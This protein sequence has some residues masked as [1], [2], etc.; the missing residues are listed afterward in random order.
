MKIIAHGHYSKA[1][2]DT[3]LNDALPPLKELVKETT[4]ESVRRVGRFIQLALIG[5]G[6]CLTL[7][8]SKQKTLPADTA[9]YL[10]SGR[11]DLEITL[12]VLVQMVEH[13]LPPKPLSFINTV[14][15]SA[16]FYIAKHFGIRGRNQFV[17]R[18]HA[19]L[20]CALQLAALDLHT[21][22]VQTALVGSVD[23]CTEPLADHRK[24]LDVAEDTTVGEGSHWFLLTD[25]SHAD[26]ALATIVDVMLL[27]DNDSLQ[28]WLNK[29]VLDDTV[30][31]C[32]QHVDPVT[33]T[34]LQKITGCTPWHAT[35]DL[36]WYDSHCGHVLGEFLTLRPAKKILH[37][38]SDPDGRFNVLLVSLA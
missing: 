27:S 4:G 23:I 15:N 36:H 5:A 28:Q 19:P 34:L 13:G 26:T 9:V 6:R 16:C 24:R 38:D 29:Q 14:S 20:E 32:G 12:D 8:N 30:L 22:A 2:G 10:T 21:N 18:R 17:T 33:A 35:A 31:V 3:V 7:F 11:G 1:V 25:D 37:I